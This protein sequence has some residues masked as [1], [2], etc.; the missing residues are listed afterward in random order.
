MEQVNRG[1]LCTPSDS[2][3]I[4]VL[5]ARQLFQKFFDKGRVEKNFLSCQNQRSVFT[6]CLEMKMKY[7]SSSSGILEQTCQGEKSHKFSERIK[8]IGYRI[9]NTFSKNFISEI[10]DKIHED[11]KRKKSS[12]D[13]ECK[14]GKKIRKLQ[15]E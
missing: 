10:N 8:S 7:D 15:S 12:S 4:C 5:Y 13:K 2:I 11:K 14:N 9:F 6:A 1:G 3:Y